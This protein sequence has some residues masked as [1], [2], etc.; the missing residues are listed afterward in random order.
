MYVSHSF[1]YRSHE[2]NRY[3]RGKVFL[4]YFFPNS[5]FGLKLPNFVMICLFSSSLIRIITTYCFNDLMNIIATFRSGYTTPID[6]CTPWWIP[7][8]TSMCVLTVGLFCK[9]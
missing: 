7:D 4:C 5:S 3:E 9:K 6:I 1:Q 2:A 8:I